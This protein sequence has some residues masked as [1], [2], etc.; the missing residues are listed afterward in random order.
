MKKGAIFIISLIILFASCT[1]D[2]KAEDVTSHDS[3]KIESR[4]ER[5]DE[6]Y[7]KQ[8]QCAVHDGKSPKR[9]AKRIKFCRLVQDEHDQVSDDSRY[10][11][12][13]QNI[14]KDENGRDFISFPVIQ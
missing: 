12:S 9:R 2:E 13:V 5:A 14:T 11:Q 10:D 7:C 8:K 3:A 6:G 1:N 4:I